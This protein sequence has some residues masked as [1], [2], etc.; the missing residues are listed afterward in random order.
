MH[1]DFDSFFASV[2]KALNPKLM[3]RPV[4]V[5]AGVIASCCYV[6]R[7]H[8]LHNGMPLSRARRLCPD[9]VILEGSQPTYRAVALKIFDLLREVSPNVETFLD[10]AYVELTGTERLYGAPIQIGDWLRKRVR[11]ETGLPLTVGIGSSRMV[12]RLAGKGAKPDGLGYVPPGDESDFVGRFPI[13]DLPGVGF[14]YGDI[15]ERLRIRTIADLRNMPLEALTDLFHS[16][17]EILYRRCRGEDT[18]V[19]EEREVPKSISRES[20][21]H[22]NTADR[23]EIDGM[24]FYLS[25]RAARTLRQ[26]GLEA[27][28][29]RTR[30]RYGGGGS[31]AMARSLTVPTDQHAPLFEKAL[32]ILDRI[33][34]RREALHLVG[35]TLSGIRMANG[36]QL[37]LLAQD[38]ADRE[39]HLNDALDEVRDRFGYS[40]VVAGKSL[41]LLGK[42]EQN[43][44]GFVLRTPSL[45][46]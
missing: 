22:V 30:V 1:V 15:L 20:S 25:E 24:L 6:A 29:V 23:K 28:T 21:F 31:E 3:D 4:I 26:L 39:E 19:V 44:Y 18:A 13:R 46:K 12:A 10:D 7:A 41:D 42:L 17:G 35:V 37:D 9:V 32:T 38:E 45:T 43:D 2:E 36:R 11:A 33:Y 5:G 16:H 34:G 40:A 14:R 8:G 27:R